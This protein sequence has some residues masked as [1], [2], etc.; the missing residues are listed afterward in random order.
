MK[1][2]FTLL[3]FV[4]GATSMTAQTKRIA[5]RSHS[6]SDNSLTL[7]G[8]S[9]FGLGSEPHFWI[10]PDTLRA[11][12]SIPPAPMPES[13]PSA[14]PPAPPSPTKPEAPE[15]PGQQVEPSATEQPNSSGKH[16]S[17]ESPTTPGISNGSE[18]APSG[19]THTAQVMENRSTENHNREGRLTWLALALALPATGLVLFGA[20]RRNRSD[21][22]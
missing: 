3:L 17:V 7:D 20:M 6:G 18:A 5:H 14:V 4:L 2:L 21:V 11:I 19:T 10:E 16:D 9:N 1:A 22:G 13:L 8:S 15:T 12:D